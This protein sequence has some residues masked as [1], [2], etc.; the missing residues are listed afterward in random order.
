MK[1][2]LRSIVYTSRKWIIYPV[3]YPEGLRADDWEGRRKSVE[4]LALEMGYE[5]LVVDVG[6][7]GS[8]LLPILGACDVVYM[9]VK[10]DG[11][12][13]SQTGRA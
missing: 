3:R 12:S 7:P 6:Q 4:K 5:Y 9:P 11:I 13:A 8:S 1:C 2:A 10:E